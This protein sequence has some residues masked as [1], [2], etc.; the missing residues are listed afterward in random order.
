M[1]NMDDTETFEKFKKILIL[2]KKDWE[3]NIENTVF[4]L[5]VETEL[6]INENESELLLNRLKQRGFVYTPF[7]ENDMFRI[8]DKGITE[9]ATTHNPEYQEQL[10]E[11]QRVREFD[12]E[13]EKIRQEK[14]ED[15]KHKD[16][17]KWTKWGVIGAIIV[18][19]IGA[20]TG[21]ISLVISTS[22]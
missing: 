3:E 14:R 21:I 6:S 20:I 15:K 11:E 10:L 7:R 1:I 4:P 8:T 13:Q 17:I 16:T 5:Q 9:L 22:K 19:S 2:L 18:A 12:D